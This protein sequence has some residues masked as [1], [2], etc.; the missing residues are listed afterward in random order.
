MDFFVILL[1]KILDNSKESSN[2]ASEIRNNTIRADLT[3]K[4]GKKL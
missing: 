3:V 4:S 1:S 2:L